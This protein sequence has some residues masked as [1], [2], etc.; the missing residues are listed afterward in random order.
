[1]ELMSSIAQ[2]VMLWSRRMWR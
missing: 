1:M 2:I